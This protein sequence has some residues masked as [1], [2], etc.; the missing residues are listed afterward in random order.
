L[1]RWILL[2]GVVLVLVGLFD[3]GLQGL[4]TASGLTWA[5]A[6]ILLGGFLSLAALIVSRKHGGSMHTGR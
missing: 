1:H 6:L 5:E 3:G 2:V 4:T